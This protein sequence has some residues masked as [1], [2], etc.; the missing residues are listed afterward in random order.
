MAGI[1]AKD[2]GTSF[3]TMLGFL[4]HA[5]AGMRRCAGN[6]ELAKLELAKIV[7]PDGRGIHSLKSRLWIARCG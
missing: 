4:R 6:L 2:A 7:P 3:C 1:L 5:G